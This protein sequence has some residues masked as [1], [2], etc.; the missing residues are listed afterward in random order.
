MESLRIAVRSLSRGGGN[1]IKIA[2]LGLGLFMGLLLVAKVVFELSYDNFYPDAERVFAVRTD[3]QDGGSDFTTIGPLASALADEV[4]GIEAATRMTTDSGAQALEWDGDGKAE[5]T[6]IVADKDFFSVLP[7]PVIAGAGSEAL[8]VAGNVLVS[9]SMALQMG[10]DAQGKDALGKTVWVNGNRDELYTV[11][12]IYEDV[13]DNTHQPSYDAIMSMAIPRHA[14][15]LT[16]WGVGNKFQS[17][18]R[19]AP[20]VEVASL[21]PAIRRVQE[22]HE[23]VEADLEAGR[24]T[25]YS[26]VPIRR[27]HSDT[28]ESRRNVLILS[29][30]AV[31][32]LV[33]AVMNYV[34]VDIASVPN[35][36]KGVATRRCY[37][38]RKRNIVG[39]V[40]TESL[41]HVVLSLGVAAVL[42]VA[43]R[44]FVGG[45]LE[46]S[47]GSLLGLPVTGVVIGA[48]CVVILAV[49]VFVPARMLSDVLVAA[50][51]RSYKRSGRVWK[52]SLLGV[53]FAVSAFI[54]VF[55]GSVQ[56]QYSMMVNDDPGYDYAGL[57]RI[58]AR[59]S[60]D[61]RIR[62]VDELR[63]MPQVEGVAVSMGL[64]YDGSRIGGNSVSFPGVED[65]IE[66]YDP[67]VAS[68]NYPEV[69]G[70][71]IVEGPGFTA[72][73]ANESS[74]VSRSLADRIEALM[75]WE[76][77]VGHT[78]NLPLHGES[79][80]V[81]V[82]D[83][84]MV[85]DM[86]TMD[87]RPSAIFM[88]A[89]PADPGMFG[90]SEVVVRLSEFSGENIAAVQAAV[91]RTLPGRELYVR[92]MRDELHGRYRATLM[93]RNSVLA[94]CLVILAIAMAGLIGFVHNETNRRAAEI[95]IRRIHGAS[96]RGVLRLMGLDV[97]RIALVALVPGAV[98]AVF[99][100]QRW[101][102]SFSARAPLPLTLFGAGCVALLAVIV[103]VTL[104]NSLRIARRNPVESLKSE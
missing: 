89:D 30:L 96:A 13:P 74:V 97:G 5:G 40:F 35:R 81:G 94:A 47:L 43:L 54:V 103:A 71:E 56:N 45:A 14:R 62:L 25:R 42:A 85:G 91:D 16:A 88:F 90:V 95:A 67:G 9:R 61:D 46:V 4:P 18:V 44:D 102:Q 20:G 36:A 63:R 100:A 8:A 83:D 41:L 99:A 66:I 87:K 24:D 3:R 12:G 28:P 51:F 76:S 65:R 104:L 1:V 75:G 52:L 58:P 27:V 53:Q 37:G 19:L 17:Y 11:A 49:A 38:A 82:Y 21:A 59:V 78:M 101:L 84:I 92:Q 50:V 39:M 31:V 48:I 7:R 32:V 22:V 15:F 73:S 72:G 60:N 29:I 77:V 98:G 2:C 55:L 93:F 86:V 34:L 80:I 64:P 68:P 23:D 79:T 69:M 70:I 57:L 33:A 6:N 10:D 26:L